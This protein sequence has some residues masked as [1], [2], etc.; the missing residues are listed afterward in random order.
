MGRSTGSGGARSALTWRRLARSR[1][2]QSAAQR[3]LAPDLLGEDIVLG[4]AKAEDLS[5]Q[6]ARLSECE[7]GLLPPHVGASK[8]L[9]VGRTIHARITSAM[10]WGCRRM[11][12]GCSLEAE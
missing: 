6:P 12:A 8:A 3:F 10:A 11:G 4:P 1:F 7:R 5:E 2:D 9:G